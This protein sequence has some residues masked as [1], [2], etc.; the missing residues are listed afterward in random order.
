MDEA[1]SVLTLSHGDGID[2]GL[3]C[4]REREEAGAVKVGVC[5]DKKKK[6]K[7]TELC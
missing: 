1:R 5:R 7:K 3:M 4:L 2:A 6:K